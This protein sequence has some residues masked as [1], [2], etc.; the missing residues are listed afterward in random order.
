MWLCLCQPHPSSLGPNKRKAFGV[1]GGDAVE[2]G[3]QN[4]KL[5]F[6]C[7]GPMHCQSVKQP[8][9]RQAFLSLRHLGSQERHPG[10][11]YGQVKGQCLL[12]SFLGFS[13]RANLSNEI[14]TYPFPITICFTRSAWSTCRFISLVLSHLL[15]RSLSLPYSKEL[16]WPCV[17]LFWDF[18]AVIT[19][20]W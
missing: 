11:H 3:A 17:D 1:P 19:N 14:G 15:F 4:G 5:K 9:L 16:L 18:T 10:I 20:L 13:A 8:C 12:G 7:V 2:G 6:E